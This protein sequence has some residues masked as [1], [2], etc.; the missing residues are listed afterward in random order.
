MI[1]ITQNY[2]AYPASAQSTGFKKFYAGG[3]VE[4]RRNDIVTEWN[5]VFGVL[6][7]STFLNPFV[8]IPTAKK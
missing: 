8:D 1:R 5:Y 7:T 3:M 2:I 4:D 6:T